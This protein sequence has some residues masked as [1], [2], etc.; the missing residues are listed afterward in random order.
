MEFQVVAE[1]ATQENI[2]IAQ[3][4]QIAD[5]F[6]K[7]IANF[8]DGRMEVWLGGVYSLER[9]AADSPEYHW[10]IME[11]LTTYVR[12]HAKRNQQG[13]TPLNAKA[14]ST[15]PTSERRLWMTSA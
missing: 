15:K 4:G 9:I 2:R 12:T 5:R 10:Q 7:A 14:E 11:I 13:K 3:Q 6:T 1:K 8:G